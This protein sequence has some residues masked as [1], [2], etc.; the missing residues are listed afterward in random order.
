MQSTSPSADKRADFF[1]Y[2]FPAGVPPLWCPL[3]THYDPKGN[4]WQNRMIAHLRHLAPFIKG[5][6]IPGSTGDGWELHDRETKRV[7]EIALDQAQALEF[8]LLIGLL[9]PDTAAVLSALESTVQLLMD[10]TGESEPLSA[11]QKA[12]VCGFA[13]CP[14]FGRQVQQDEILTGLAS[15]LE[16]GFPIALYQLPQVTKSEM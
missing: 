4:I 9:K 10:R 11:L 8:S 6:L 12:R 13:V 16:S 2:L 7:I 15:V 3:L 1:A 14:P 5:F